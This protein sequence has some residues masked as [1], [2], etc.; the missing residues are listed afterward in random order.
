MDG[1]DV[2]SFRLSPFPP[3]KPFVFLDPKTPDRENSN[4]NRAILKSSYESVFRVNNKKDT[5]DQFEKIFPPG[6][7]NKVVV[8]TTLRGVRRTFEECNAVRAEIEGL[9]VM[10]VKHDVSMD[11]GFREK[12][13]DLMKGKGKEATVPPWV[14]VNRRYIG[15]SEEVLKILEEGLLGE[16]LVRCPKK[17][18]GSVCEGCG[19]ARL[20]PNTIILLFFPK[21]LLQK[22]FTKHCCFISQLLILTAHHKQLFFKAHQYQ[23][24]P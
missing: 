11:S 23:T 10:I 22:K 16:I 2:D 7:E 17:K 6:R 24:S 15:G 21:S 18:A 19:K 1:L 9:R 13:S 12:L 4:L 14:F 8:Y 3:P 20:L 5:L